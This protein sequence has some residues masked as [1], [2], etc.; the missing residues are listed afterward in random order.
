MNRAII[1][2]RIRAALGT[3]LLLSL[4]FACSQQ[5]VSSPTPDP[6]SVL[7]AAVQTAMARMT[8]T[9]SQ[10][11]ATST[12]TPVPLT[13]TERPIEFTPSPSVTVLAG[14]DS[15][16]RAEFVADITVPDGTTFGPG[17][18]FVKTWR[19]MNAGEST[20]TRDY[21]LVFVSG[22]QMAAPPRIPFELTVLPGR[23]VD[24]SVTLTAPEF[25]G[26]QRGFWMLA[27]A[28]GERFGIGPKFDEPFWVEIQ[29]A[30]GAAAPTSPAAGAV[31]GASLS[32]DPA[33]FSGE[34]PQTFIFSGEITL[35][36][37]ARV[38]LQLEAGANQPG[39]EY[40]L[41]AAQ[42][43]DLAAG[44]AAVQYTLD[45][46]DT[47]VGWARLHITAPDDV[48]SNQANFSLTCQ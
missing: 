6:A 10:P 12:R 39:Y 21:A 8:A 23:T 5:A 32:V 43:L 17:E 37:P 9:A 38:T 30:G 44:T 45:L 18:R 2:G 16:D 29:V 42:T 48:L 40:N 19:L 13:P 7:T 20:W 46:R 14:A 3:L 22:A 35:A 36:Q 28:A 11:Q 4:S 34:C 24:L 33:S 47:V 26:L 25:N 15:G 31:T 27:N 1:T 41:P